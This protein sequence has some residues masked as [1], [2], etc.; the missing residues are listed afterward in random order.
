MKIGLIGAGNMASALA[1]GWGEPVVVSDADHARAQAL[2]DE[3]GGEALDSNAYVADAV[4]AIVLCHKPAQLQEVADEIRD[5]AGA[6][7]ADFVTVTGPIVSASPWCELAALE[8]DATNDDRLA[9]VAHGLVDR[10]QA[11]RL[12]QLHERG[13]RLVVLAPRP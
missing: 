10:L 13:A 4:D 12:A 7:A 2:V 3:L 1:R 8:A 9:V 6:V 11:R 5:R